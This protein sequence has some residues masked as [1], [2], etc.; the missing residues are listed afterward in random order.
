MYGDED[1]FDIFFPDAESDRKYL[2]NAHSKTA[3]LTFLRM[4]VVWLVWNCQSFCRYFSVSNGSR[5]ELAKSREI[6][7]FTDRH[8]E[9]F[10]W[11]VF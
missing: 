2:R 6:K 3:R 9:I 7:V 11:K 1:F 8:G 5:D 10:I 4:R